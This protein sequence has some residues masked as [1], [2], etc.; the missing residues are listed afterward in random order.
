MHLPLK[1]RRTKKKHQN[2]RTHVAIHS[3]LY[4]YAYSQN[5]RWPNP[6]DSKYTHTH[7]HRHS[8]PLNMRIFN[9]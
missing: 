6:L 7:T 1:K 3:Q 5:I 8:K 2:N 9:I 4:F